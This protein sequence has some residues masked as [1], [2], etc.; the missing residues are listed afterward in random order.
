MRARADVWFVM[1][2]AGQ[3]RQARQPRCLPTHKHA[4]MHHPSARAPSRPTRN[5]VALSDITKRLASHRPRQLQPH[6]LSPSPC[7]RH[8]DPQIRTPLQFS[9][10]ST[11][12]GEVYQLRICVLCRCGHSVGRRSGCYWPSK[13]IKSDLDENQVHVQHPDPRPCVQRERGRRREGGGGSDVR[14]TF[15]STLGASKYSLSLSGAN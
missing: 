1:P 9:A 2:R 15:I 8:P 4:R 12:A 13:N 11:S 7:T 10:L 14:A 6:I 5:P 3:H